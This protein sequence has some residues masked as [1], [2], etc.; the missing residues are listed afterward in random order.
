MAYL[1]L[2]RPYGDRDTIRNRGW[3]WYEDGSNGIETFGF[4]FRHRYLAPCPS[5]TEE[6]GVYRHNCTVATSSAIDTTKDLCGRPFRSG[7]NFVVETA[8][9]P[10]VTCGGRRNR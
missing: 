8:S 3:H 1:P 4:E 6:D 2:N 10:G 9:G 5:V 7:S